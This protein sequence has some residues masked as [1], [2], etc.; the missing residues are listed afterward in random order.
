MAALNIL[1]RYAGATYYGPHIHSR[2]MYRSI[3]TTNYQHVA[4]EHEDDAVGT[5]RLIRRIFETV[6]NQ[7]LCNEYVLTRVPFEVATS[8]WSFDH[9]IFL[10]GEPSPYPWHHDNTPAPYAP[11]Q[12]ELDLGGSA[13]FLRAAHEA[14]R[15]QLE[16]LAARHAAQNALSQIPVDYDE[17]FDEFEEAMAM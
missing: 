3:A 13:A 2:R 15:E 7:A 17:G 9:V 14:S 11:P 1:P 16:A 4:E 12:G 5:T 10:E 8:G 6:G